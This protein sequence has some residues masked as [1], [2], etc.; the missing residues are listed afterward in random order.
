VSGAAVDTLIGGTGKDVFVV[1][2]AADVVS[3]GS[4]H[5]TDTI[6][7]TVSYVLPSNVANLTLTGAANLTATGNALNNMLTANSGADTLIAGSGVDTLVGGTGSDLFVVDNTKDVVNVATGAGNDTIQSSVNYTASANVANL[8]L[9]GTANLTGTGNS[10]ADVITAN[11]GNDTLTAGTGAA[12]LIGGAGTDTFVVNSAADVVEEGASGTNSVIESS[13]S[14]TLPVNVNTLILSGSAALTA[15]ANGANDSITANSGADTLIGGAGAD[16]LQSGSGIDS[17][18]GGSGTDLFVIK[19]SKDSISV[20]SLGNDTVDASVSYVL[21]AN[22][23]YLAL[24]GSGNLTATGNAQTDLITGNSGN[25]VLV[26]GSGIAVLEGGETGGND[27]IKAAGNQA[28]L[29]ADAGAATLTGGAFRDFFAAG[30]GGDTITTGATDN[31]VAV[32]LGDGATTLKPT[33]GAANVLSLG[34]GIDTESLFFSK[35]GNNLVLTD[36]TSGDAITFTNWYANSHN[37]NFTILQVVEAASASYASGGS[38]PLRNSALEEFSF[39][40]LVNQ[41]NAAGSPANWALSNGMASAAL[42]DSA[43]AAYGGDLAYYYGL[44]RNLSG[45]NL[46]A[47]Q[48]T[49]TNPGFGSAAQTIDSLASISGGP[50]QLQADGVAARVLDASFGAKPDPVRHFVDPVN[51]NWLILHGALD[52]IRSGSGGAEPLG[53]MPDTVPGALLVAP[54]PNIHP[55]LGF[56]DPFAAAHGTRV[57]VA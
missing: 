15:T 32:N 53:E 4:T 22:I 9:T 33:T 21:P 40:A 47:A 34:G 11:S 10:L 14:Y 31:V 35:S 41:F 55:R 23:A 52:Q 38:D 54:T 56:A 50:L 18:V 5:G 42:T 19:N 30:A 7:S 2:N 43:T 44:D 28:A 6:D 12:T 45:L 1:N 3:V 46:S 17:L 20:A 36:G 8:T 26:G 13:A 29:I 25:D 16:T 57:D 51:L 37:Q 24:T 39:T 49:L 48:A 27:Q